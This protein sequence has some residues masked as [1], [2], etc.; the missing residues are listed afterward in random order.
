MNTK[1]ILC[2]GTIVA[3]VF[4]FTCMKATA[5]LPP[6]FPQLSILPNTNPAPGYLVLSDS[7]FPGWEARVDGRPA[8]ILCANYLVRAVA[9]AAG[10]HQVVF[11]YRP[12]PWRIGSKFSLVS[13]LLLL[14]MALGR[15]RSPRA[16][17]PS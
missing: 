2:V 10:R 3:L 7:Y 5:Q 16:G 8:R 17:A 13:G 12:W 9:L 15:R 14:G 1:R 6:D 4:G 11:S